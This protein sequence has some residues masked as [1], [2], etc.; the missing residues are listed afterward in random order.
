MKSERSPWAIFALSFLISLAILVTA[1]IAILFFSVKSWGKESSSAPVQ[2]REIDL[3]MQN[4]LPSEQDH[5]AVLIIFCT[6]R[7]LPPTHY[8]LLDFDALAAELTLIP[9]PKETVVTVGVRE[10]TINGHYDY[11]GCENARLAAES[12]ALAAVDRYIRITAK[13]L[14][15]LIDT[16]GGLELSL[17]DGYYGETLSLPPGKNLLGGELTCKFAEESGQWP[18]LLRE[19]LI[20]RLN[21][22]LADRGDYL[23]QVL[24]NNA[25]TSI[26]KLDVSSSQKAVRYFLQSPERTVSLYQPDGVWSEQGAR[27]LL[28][29]DSVK[30]LREILF[31]PEP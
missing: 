19:L 27:F 13:G 3:S 1:V 24:L 4:Y 9:L 7:N 14:A 2:S 5:A 29:E 25:D 23:F 8:F 6:Q 26:T 15:V 18:E 31:R 12:A 21:E 11:A 20:Q 10:D 16:L 22:N 28:N 30:A 17:P